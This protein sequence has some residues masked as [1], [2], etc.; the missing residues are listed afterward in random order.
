M[1]SRQAILTSAGWEK[2]LAA[3]PGDMMAAFSVSRLQTWITR[4]SQLSPEHIALAELSLRQGM[5]DLF[6]QDYAWPIDIVSV[7]ALV[8]AASLV[9]PTFS[10]READTIVETARQAAQTHLENGREASTLREEAAA[11]GNL[12][13]RLGLNLNATIQELRDAADARDQDEMLDDDR[14]PRERKRFDE[15]SESIDVDELFLGLMDR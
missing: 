11:L 7:D 12:Q 9:H 1:Q 10:H 13:K 8:E 6:A 2:T 15:S 3:V 5:L 4:S 14:A